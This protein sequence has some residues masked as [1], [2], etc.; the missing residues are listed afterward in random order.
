MFSARGDSDRGP[1]YE[2]VDVE[3]RVGSSGNNAARHS[4]SQS[5]SLFSMCTRPCSN[6]S[7]W[8]IFYLSLSVLILIATAT[9]VGLKMTTGNGKSPSSPSI[10]WAPTSAPVAPTR[11][12]QVQELVLT[13][14]SDQVLSNKKSP[15]YR[16][17]QWILNDDPRHVSGDDPDL[18]QRYILA[19]LYFSTNNTTRAATTWINA[20]EWMSLQHECNWFGIGCEEEALIT[21]AAGAA[22]GQSLFTQQFPDNSLPQHK[23]KGK[24]ILINLTSN[25]LRGTLPKEISMLQYLCKWLSWLLFCL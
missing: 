12:Q 25:G 4:R 10:T 5:R 3:E 20:H 6:I 1:S 23:S 16:A 2:G 15:Q 8:D 21:L 9:Y 14:T 22:V 17:Y 13:A 18:L 19:I 11:E 24:I 7:K